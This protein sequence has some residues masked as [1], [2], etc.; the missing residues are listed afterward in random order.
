MIDF[1]T[2]KDV[3]EHQAKIGKKLVIF[4]GSV[5]DVT[6]F[7]NQHPGGPEKIE[8]LLGKVIDEA[9]AEAEHTRSARNIFRDLK[10]LGVLSGGSNKGSGSFSGTNT[11][12]KGLD[13]TILDS[14]IKIDY[15]KGIFW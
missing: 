8:P 1:T 12:V 7:L 9:Y 14:K 3:Q 10:K 4:E 15:T 2:E 6:E 13:G 11:N 5:Y